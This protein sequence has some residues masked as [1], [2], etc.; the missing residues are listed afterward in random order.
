MRVGFGSLHT[1]HLDAV[2]AYVEQ[3]LG[4]MRQVKKREAAGKKVDR[5]EMVT[6]LMSKEKFK[7]FFAEMKV[8]QAKE[9]PKALEGLECPV[10]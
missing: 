7:E 2:R 6:R 8:A 4:E 3:R 5:K 1:N 10:E 9:E